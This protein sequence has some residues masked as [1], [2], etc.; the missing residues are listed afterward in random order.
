ML[1]KFRN[2]RFRTKFFLVSLCISLIPTFVLGIFCYR[3]LNSLL[4]ERERT[5]LRDSIIQES[6]NISSWIK[7]YETVAE[8]ICWDKSLNEA[9]NSKYETN[10]Q[11]Y[12]AYT[13]LIEPALSSVEFLTAG[14]NELVVYTDLEIIPKDNTLEPLYT[15]Q[16]YPWFNDVLL[17]ANTFPISIIDGSSILIFDS[18]VDIPKDVTAFICVQLE[19]DV[20]FENLTTLFD[21][22]YG[23]LITDAEDK[24]IWSYHTKDITSFTAEVSIDDIRMGNYIVENTTDLHTEWNY[25]IYRPTQSVVGPTKTIIYT[26][27]FTLLIC[28]TLILMLSYWFSGTLVRPLERLAS[29]MVKVAQGEY[30]IMDTPQSSD[31]VGQLMLSFSDMVTKINV[32]INETLRAKIVQQKLEFKALQAQINPH[33]LYNTLSLINSQALLAGH[34]EIG[35]LARYLS[36]FYRTSLNKGKDMI[37]VSGEIEN[38]KAYINIQ[39]IMHSNSFDVRYDIDE[40]VLGYTMPNLMLEPLIENSIMHGIEPMQSGERGLLTVSAKS[41]GTDIVFTIADNGCGIPEDILALLP[42]KHSNSYGVENVHTRAQLQYGQQYGLS[43]RSKVN[44]G[45]EV[46]LTIPKQ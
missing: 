41:V 14:I 43:Y 42:S 46:T 45:T 25:Y 13:N 28:L 23:I 18:F 16:T 37:K 22:S 8:H 12:R 36:T 24:P 7:T 31:E 35:Q 6:L 19:S 1:Q 44:C 5:A 38:A 15:L 2:L 27:V 32:L 26:V 30:E 29:N 33:F 20:L 3:Q 17:Q 21:N 11:M 10:S 40:D 4:I 34:P 9:L 39:L